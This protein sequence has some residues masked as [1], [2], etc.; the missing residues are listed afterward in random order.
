MEKPMTGITADAVMCAHRGVG[1]DNRIYWSI[2]S[3]DENNTLSWSERKYIEGWESRS[4]VSLCNAGNGVLFCAF[5]NG[6]GLLLSLRYFQDPAKG[7]AWTRDAEILGR[8]MADTTP[9]LVLYRGQLWCIHRG[10]DDGLLRYTVR[11][12]LNAPKTEWSS[13]KNVSNTDAGA[14]PAA[15]VLG[16]GTS[17]ERLYTLFKGRNSSETIFGALQKSPGDG[18]LPEFTV[19]ESGYTGSTPG[20]L[21]FDG[22]PWLVHS[23]KDKDNKIW[24]AK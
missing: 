16:V 10:D 24:T 1:G 13:D 2:G 18:W 3:Q 21:I 9:R 17:D 15:L 12:N 5:V 6:D 19:W 14:G 4:G 7:W 20:V 11:N 8:N 23:G 22:S